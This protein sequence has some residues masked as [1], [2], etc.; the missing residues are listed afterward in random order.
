MKP[1]KIFPS[2][3]FHNSLKE[4]EEMCK[5]KKINIVYIKKYPIKSYLYSL[6]EILNLSNFEKVYETAD[7]VI[8]EEFEK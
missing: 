6:E 8:Y 2:K 7:G 4:F 5:K 1:A 3:Y